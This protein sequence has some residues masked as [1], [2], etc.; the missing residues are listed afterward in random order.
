MMAAPPPT[1][2]QDPPRGEGG[3]LCARQGCVLIVE[4][5]DEFPRLWDSASTDGQEEHSMGNA[6]H[7]ALH[8]LSLLIILGAGSTTRIPSVQQYLKERK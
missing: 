6:P 7:D 4:T 2:L 1:V 8:W 5:N 3:V